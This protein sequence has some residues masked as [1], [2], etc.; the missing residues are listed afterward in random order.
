MKWETA[1]GD[2]ERRREVVAIE[3]V[4]VSANSARMA[5]VMMKMIM[6]AP[7]SN[8]LRVKGTPRTK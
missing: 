8:L 6:L 7:C 4:S 5:K 2:Y 3:P 1:V